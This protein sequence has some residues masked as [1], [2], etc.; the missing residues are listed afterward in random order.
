MF[1]PL[2][3]NVLPVFKITQSEMG[4][5]GCLLSLPAKMDQKKGFAKEAHFNSNFY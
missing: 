4:R 3:E 2:R 5:L 1:V